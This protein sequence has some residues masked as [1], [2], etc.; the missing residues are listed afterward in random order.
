MLGSSPRA[1]SNARCALRL[2]D[3]GAIRRRSRPFPGRAAADVPLR[4]TV[5]TAD[6]VF[7]PSP[8][9]TTFGCGLEDGARSLGSEL[10]DG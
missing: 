6:R 4:S 3:G 9:N 5:R 8:G 7:L 2:S 10:V 1:E